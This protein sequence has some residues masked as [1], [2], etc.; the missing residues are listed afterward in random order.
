M[1]ES[2]TRESAVN[3]KQFASGTIVLLTTVLN[4]GCVP[5]DGTRD[6]VKGWSYGEQEGTS[7]R[8]RNQ[9]NCCGLETVIT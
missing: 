2:Y 1:L 9:V 6:D 7:Q 8:F 4:V 3:L 5:N